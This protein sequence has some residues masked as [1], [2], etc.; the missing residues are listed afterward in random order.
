VGNAGFSGHSAPYTRL[1]LETLPVYREADM[2]VL[3]VGINDLQASLALEGAPSDAALERSAQAFLDGNSASMRVPFHE[4]S[5]IIR[6]ARTVIVPDAPGGDLSWEGWYSRKRDQRAAA[7][8]VPLPDLGTG[9]SEYRGRIRRLGDACATLQVRCLFLTQPTIWRKD[10]TKAETDLTW[11]GWVGPQDDPKGY[12]SIEQLADAMSRYNGALLET[13]AQE[14]LECMDLAAVVPKDTSALF[15]DC[16]FNENG[17]RLV[18][19]RVAE[20]L[21]ATAPFAVR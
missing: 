8:T 9:L 1:L 10:L 17:A 5:W 6:R 20:Y 16:H 11:F 2:I 14:R 3:L 19:A 12:V 13:C 7:R 21:R 4:R 18:A 15:D